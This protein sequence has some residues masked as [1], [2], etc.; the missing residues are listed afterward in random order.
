M[1]SSS[2]VV[3]AA[4]HWVKPL[5]PACLSDSL[6]VLRLVQ[7]SHQWAA[8]HYWVALSP[9]NISSA[10]ERLHKSSAHHCDSYLIIGLCATWS[11]PV[12]MLKSL[13]TQ[14]LAANWSRKPAWF[15]RRWLH[16]QEMSYE[17]F[18]ATI[19]SWINLVARSW[20]SNSQ[21]GMFSIQKNMSH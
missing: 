3:L 9:L 5:Y 20:S 15:A 12:W 14:T 11:T 1:C 10:S 6:S 17:L 16:L 8:W 19:L 21:Q 18:L 13:I 7:L 2:C 4:L